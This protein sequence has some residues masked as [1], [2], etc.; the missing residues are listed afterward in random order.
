MNRFYYDL[1]V[2]SCLSPCGDNESTPDSIAGMAELNGLNIVAL[3]DHNSTKNCP[4]FAYAAKNHGITPIFGMELTT[5]EDIHMVCL[6]SSL[7]DAMA[8]D[9]EIE[10]Q[11]IKVK[12]KP[13]VF[14]NQFVVD[15]NDNV[16]GEIEHLLINATALSLDDA[17]ELTEKFGGVCYPA[18]IDRTSNSTTSVLGVFPNGFKIAELHDKTKLKEFAAF[19]GLS[20][21]NIIISSDAHYLWDISEK[22]NFL[23]LDA[24]YNDTEQ[25]VKC[26]FERL[27]NPI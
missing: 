26:L 22:E 18:H 25:I 8:F 17:K 3:T 5:S 4:A 19:S 21:D 27:H 14:G 24:D 7:D 2:H 12:N 6:F 10:K 20:S 13:A 11:I 9:G 15:H 16:M 23:M 1:H